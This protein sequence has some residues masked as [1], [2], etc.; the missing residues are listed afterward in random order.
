MLKEAAAQGHP[1]V[2]GT[3]MAPLAAKAEDVA[4]LS[5]LLAASKR[6]LF[7]FGGGAK[8][9]EGVATMLHSI[10]AASFTTYAGRG[11]VAPDAPLHFGSTL[12]RPGSADVIAS[13]DL[14]IAVGTELAEVETVNSAALTYLNRLSDW[15]FVAGRMANDGGKD[16]VLWVP[17]ANR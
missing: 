13:A 11:V 14:V 17:G 12:A 9:A 10:G 4:K 7:I 1:P 3:A 2:A 8:H 5:D 15:F 16:D 6:P